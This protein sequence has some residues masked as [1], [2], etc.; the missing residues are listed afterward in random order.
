VNARRG[1]FDREWFN[2][3]KIRTAQPSSVPYASPTAPIVWDPSHGKGRST[4]AS[5][6]HEVLNAEEVAVFLRVDQK[7]VYDYANRNQI[8]HRRLGR[9]LLFSRSALVAWLADCW[10]AGRA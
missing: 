5:G 4:A 8:P 7:T 2:A 1:Q 10:G 9:R 6:D 3:P